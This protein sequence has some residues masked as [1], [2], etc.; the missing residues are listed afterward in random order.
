MQD[1]CSV[2]SVSGF[3]ILLDVDYDDTDI[4]S[5]ARLAWASLINPADGRTSLSDMTSAA[6]EMWQGTRLLVWRQLLQR[7]VLLHKVPVVDQPSVIPA[8]NALD[9]LFVNGDDRPLDIDAIVSA[10]AD[11]RAAIDRMLDSGNVMPAVCRFF[12]LAMTFADHFAKDRLYNIIGDAFNPD[13]TLTQIYESIIA[14]LS[15]DSVSAAS[16][17]HATV[18]IKKGMAELRE[19]DAWKYFH[20]PTFLRHIPPQ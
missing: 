13:R 1:G 12:T 4:D 20:F 17:R 11:R 3:S 2:A 9:S 15:T 6:V 14:A 8:D 10:I 7:Y 18:Y 5:M 19:T 16:R